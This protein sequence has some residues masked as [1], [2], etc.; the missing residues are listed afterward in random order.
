MKKLDPKMIVILV[1]VTLII[2]FSIQNSETVA[3]KLFFWKISMPRVLL[4]MGS[5]LVGVVI[6]VLYPVKLKGK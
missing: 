4:I 5:V 6:G 1:I 2:I 3:V